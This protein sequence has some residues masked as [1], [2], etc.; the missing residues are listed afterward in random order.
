MKSRNRPFEA[1]AESVAEL[2][3]IEGERLGRQR[4]ILAALQ[5]ETVGLLNQIAAN[6]GHIVRERS[7]ISS[8]DRE[9]AALRHETSHLREL[10]AR[11][12]A[13]IASL[14]ADL[15]RREGRLEDESCLPRPR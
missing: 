15:V 3:A 1:E 13:R 5:T 9:I 12:E 2:I 11:N 10:A 14:H 7:F 8:S 4:Q 6:E